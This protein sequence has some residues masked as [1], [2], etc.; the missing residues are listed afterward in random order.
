MT[1]QRAFH[2][3][4]NRC[5]GCGAC[6]IACGNENELPAGRAWRQVHTFN[7]ARHP[8][9]PVVHL[10]LACNQC[11]D[12]AC[13]R[14]CPA[15]AYRKD[16]ATGVVTIDEARCIGCTYC[17]WAC[18]Y[19]APRYNPEKRL[20]EK[21]TFCA[22][23]LAEGREPACVACCPTGA[24]QLDTLTPA[25]DPAAPGFTA[26]GLGPAI[27]FTLPRRKSPPE[28][29]APPDPAAVA[30][31]YPGALRWPAAKI[32][33]RSEW[34]L[35]LF[36]WTAVV[37]AALAAAS[38][39]DALAVPPLPFLAA[40]AAALLL[41]AFHLGRKARAWR[42]AANWRTSWLSREIVLFPLF[43][44]LAGAHLLRP[45][46]PHLGW[47][48]A[49]AGFAALIA[50]DR[51][52]QVA[53]Q[54]GPLNFLSDQALLTGFFLT[55]VLYRDPWLYVPAGGLKLALYA[56]RKLRRWDGFRLGSAAMSA[57]RV[58]VGFGL[59]L[60]GLLMGGPA[61]SFLATV[62]VIAGEFIDRCEFYGELEVI[63]P[64]R[65]LR[66]DLDAALANTEGSSRQDVKTQR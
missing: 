43:L 7:E 10:S 9:L 16:P 12:P 45:D 38:A 36:T 63:T 28:L 57:L 13:L 4:L 1:E 32:T 66:L 19:D 55:G 61:G 49:V 56:Y 44:A 64:R 17:A 6:V 46:R 50:I 15:A 14:H 2:V 11:A 39:G 54:V 65:Q 3:D 23:R 48:A 18:P 35:A 52:Y 51:V 37:L 42:A 25:G 20:M 21:C 58:A 26:A 24:L 30:A 31:L 22:E 59:P 41:S 27:R 62:A 40:G 29:T 53:M 34:P 5:T 33:L 8:A 60:P 47:I